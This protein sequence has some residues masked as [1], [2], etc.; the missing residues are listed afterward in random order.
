MK[1]Q[2]INVNNY[3][4]IKEEYSILVTQVNKIE[5]ELKNYKNK[6]KK[7]VQELAEIEF[8]TEKQIQ[9]INRAKIEEGFIKEKQLQNKCKEAVDYFLKDING[10]NDDIY[11]STLSIRIEYQNMKIF[12][13]LTDLN[14]TFEKLKEETKLQFGKEANEFYFADENGN[15]FLDELK[16]I[17]ALFPLSKVKIGN[18]EP[19]INVVDKIHP[20]RKIIT[21]IEE[22][23]NMK[24]LTKI[25]KKSIKEKFNEWF[26]KNNLN[27]LYLILYI[28]WLI[29]WSKSRLN[30]LRSTHYRVFKQSNQILIDNAFFSKDTTNFM[31]NLGVSLN[32]IL[33]FE[34]IRFSQFNH[35]LGNIR[36]IQKRYKDNAQCSNK[37]I[38]Y[39]S[40]NC[41]DKTKFLKNKTATFNGKNYFYIKTSCSSKI[42]GALNNYDNDGYILDIPISNATK[43][44]N[45]IKENDGFFDSSKTA[46][47]M[48]M[49]NIYNRNMNMICTLRILFENFFTKILIYNTSDIFQLK[50]SFDIYTIISIIFCIFLLIVHIIN[51]FKDDSTGLERLKSKQKFK[52]PEIEECIAIVN[53]VF[54]FI[55]IIYSSLMINSSMR[56][57]PIN[58]EIFNDY[59]KYPVRYDIHNIC[60]SINILIAFIA[61]ILFFSRYLE[62]FKVI[63]RTIISFL[64]RIWPFILIW[65]VLFI[66]ICLFISHYLVGDFSDTIY[67]ENYFI[68]VKVIQSIFRGTIDNYEFP[69]QIY[70]DFKSSLQI[71]S[72]S[73]NQY[74]RIYNKIGTTGYCLYSIFVYIIINIFLK[75]S[76]I[77]FCY[78]IYRDM[79]IMS[80]KELEYN[81]IIEKRNEEKKK[82]KEL[83]KENE[84]KI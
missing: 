51:C 59:T 24:N 11:E 41:S 58:T 3:E 52:F 70:T 20:K 50:N 77:G 62:E 60:V 66:L 69:S 56:K 49:I 12:K 18:Y 83:N 84:Q 16:V 32:R 26:G 73:N 82:I 64:I 30:F 48:L 71:F 63:I 15:I 5:N 27:I 10:N 29:F 81:K 74:N 78:L 4:K 72:N 25:R 9:D 31:Q 8:Q 57:S 45:I 2:K 47:M 53:F 76:I 46:S 42:E 28:I 7:L 1:E 33:E 38:K 34:N 80:K 75:G 55:I 37:K 67:R 36:L 79:Y 44:N 43:M 61:L 13:A 68:F 21:N 39:S 17:P 6:E 54:Y 35:F 23:Q 40:G 14:I 19:I 22:F 65:I